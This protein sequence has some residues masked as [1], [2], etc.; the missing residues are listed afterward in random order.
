MKV[1][2]IGNTRLG[3]AILS[4]PIISYYNKKNNHITVICSSL[5]ANIYASFS[6]V[7][8]VIILKKK[9]RG[10]HWLEAYGRLEK[11]K[12]DLVIDLRNSILRM[13]LN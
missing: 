9:K 6:S 10:L 7:T 5:S 1:L 12:W 13:M 3:D 4:T 2:F 11:G 8:K